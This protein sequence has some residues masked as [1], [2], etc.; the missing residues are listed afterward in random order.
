M[1]NAIL[2]LKG[3]HQDGLGNIG[4]IG[5]HIEQVMDAVAQVYITAS[6]ALEH[7]GISVGFPAPIG[8][9]SA[10]RP[11][12]SLGFHDHSTGNNAINLCK[13]HLS[14]EFPGNLGYL[15]PLIKAFR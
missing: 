15:S 9:A 3:A 14:E 6:G 4:V 11:G 1:G 7:H 13:K 8:M 12:I 10:F 5:H 2:G